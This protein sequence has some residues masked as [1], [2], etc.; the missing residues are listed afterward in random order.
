MFDD[1]KKELSRLDAELRAEAYE[2]QLEKLQNQ[3]IPDLEDLFEY[4]DSDWLT[5]ADAALSE[6]ER[7]YGRPGMEPSQKRRNDA[8]DF[9]RTVYADESRKDSAAVFVEKKPKKDDKKQEKKKE[10]KDSKGTGCLP[11]II[12]MELLVI[13]VMLWWWYLWMK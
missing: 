11:V 13:A 8:V 4:E 9:H 7:L 1:P 3:E 6:E 12:L 2:D 5:Q 10:K